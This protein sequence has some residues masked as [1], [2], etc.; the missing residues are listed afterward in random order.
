MADHLTPLGFTVRTVPEFEE[1][2][3][4]AAAEGVGVDA[5]DAGAYVHWA[6]GEDGVELWVK[7]SPEGQ[8]VD[9]QP[10]F[11]PPDASPSLTLAGA[12]RVEDEGLALEGAALGAVAG[13]SLAFHVADFARGPLGTEDAALQVTAFAEAIEVF[14][15]P[16]SFS[17]ATGRRLGELDALDAR[18]EDD[19]LLA[20]WPVEARVELSGEVV[21]CDLLRNPLMNGRFWR[22]V[23]RTDVGLL[24]AVA[25][26]RAVKKRPR[27]GKVVDGIFWLSARWV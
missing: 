19:A 22:F 10:H 12:Q 3:A 4:H 24:D 8:I 5:G 6:C 7:V 13:A 16:E 21:R 17:E 23:L 1:L 18:G 11:A 9:C 25:P 15:E 14:E 2:I 20:Q 26:S 27:P